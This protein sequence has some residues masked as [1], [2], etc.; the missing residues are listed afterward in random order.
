[1]YTCIHAGR[2]RAHDSR[3]QGTVGTTDARARRLRLSRSAVARDLLAQ[4][5]GYSG[6]IDLAAEARR[7]SLLVRRRRSERE[8]LSLIAAAADWT[9]W[10]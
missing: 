9:D 1:M 4:S 8:A 3:A 5:L 6:A 10:R 2:L 7:Q